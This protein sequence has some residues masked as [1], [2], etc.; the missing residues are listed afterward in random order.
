M[1]IFRREKC[2]KQAKGVVSQLGFRLDSNKSQ[3]LIRLIYEI[4][5]RDNIPALKVIP[6]KVIKDPPQPTKESFNSLKSYLVK[7]RYSEVSKVG[8][9]EDIYLPK[10]EFDRRNSV[11]GVKKSFRPKRIFIEKNAL[12]FPLTKSIVSKFKRVPVTI[13][14]SLKRYLRSHKKFSIRDYNQ[15][16][17]SFFLVKI[18]AKLF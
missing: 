7:R 9:L 11:V 13:I 14:P 15:R 10:T 1:Q 6:P 18:Y 12:D 8:Y 17:N 2:L 3:E 16:Q 4:C 5:L